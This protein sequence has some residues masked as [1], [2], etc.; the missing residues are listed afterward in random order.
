MIVTVT[1][2]SDSTVTVDGNHPLAGRGMTFGIELLENRSGCM[3]PIWPKR[4]TRGTS[5][6]WFRRKR[7]R[8]A[9]PRSAILHHLSTVLTFA[10]CALTSERQRNKTQQSRCV[11]FATVTKNARWVWLAAT[12]RLPYASDFL[13]CKPIRLF[14]LRLRGPWRVQFGFRL[15]ATPPPARSP[16]SEPTRAPYT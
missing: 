10:G 9:A 6:K 5:D 1:Y 13:A 7:A 4:R 16:E 2:V 11:N 14:T 3:K 15:T 8:C 12:N